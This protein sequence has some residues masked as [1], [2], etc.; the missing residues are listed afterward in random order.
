MRF[1]DVMAIQYGLPGSADS[2]D[3]VGCPNH[4]GCFLR[5]GEY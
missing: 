1:V 4:G 2:G 5:R 3:G